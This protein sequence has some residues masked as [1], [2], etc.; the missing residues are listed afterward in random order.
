L[1]SNFRIAGGIG[2]RKSKEIR[3]ILAM[4]RLSPEWT[5]HSQLADNPM[6]WMLRVNGLMVN[7]RHA[8][9]ELQ[10]LAFEKGLIPFVPA[11]RAKQA[12]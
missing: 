1:T 9:I 3:D 10:R 5:L 2:Q 6:V 12:E 7:I 4:E 8:P 11:E